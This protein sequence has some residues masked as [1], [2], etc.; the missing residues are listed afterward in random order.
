MQYDKKFLLD[1]Y[2]MMVTI[3]FCEESLIEPILNGIVKCPVHL[4][5][6]QEAIAAGVSANLTENDQVFGNHRSHGHYLAKGGSLTELIGEVFCREHGCCR[7]RGGSM[8]LISPQVGFMGSAPIVAGT[9]ALAMGAALANQIKKNNCVAV[10]YFGDG[11]AG[12]GVLSEA[13]NFASINNLP[14]LFICENNFYATHM[15]INDTRKKDSIYE[16]AFPYGI[17]SVREDGNNVLNVYETSRK[18]IDKCRKGEGPY[19]IEYTTYRFRGH[20]GPDDNIQG[21]HTDIRPQE[22]VDQWKKR[23]P[24][25]IFRRYLLNEYNVQKEVLETIDDKIRSKVES[26][27]EKV[28]NSKTPN[29]REIK[30]YVFKKEIA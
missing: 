4:T 19:F 6:G 3:R 5:S 2:E 24:I 14:L 10:S 20:V 23:D 27:H 8:H 22:E 26:A 9:I 29:I 13:L 18:A 12:E 21:T 25:V 11:A 30:K 17:E 16:I 28:K 1:I 7:G 15:N